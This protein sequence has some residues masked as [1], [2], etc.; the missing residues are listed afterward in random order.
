MNFNIYN[1]IIIT[2]IIQGFIFTGI[3]CLV[4]K[5]H[6]KSTYALAAIIFSYTI[7]NSIFILPDLGIMSHS[8]MYL[9]YFLPLAS[10]FAPLIYLYVIFFLNPYKQISVK[11]YLLFLPFSLFFLGIMFF[12]FSLLLGYFSN[13]VVNNYFESIIIYHDLFSIIYSVIILIITFYHVIKYELKYTSFNLK[14]IR[15]EIKWLKITLSLFMFF[16]LLY[17]YLVVKDIF[18]SEVEINYYSLWIAMSILIY[19]LGHYGIYN[20]AIIIDRKDIRNFNTNHPYT[21]RIKT[22][23]NLHINDLKNLLLHQK[24]YLDSSLSLE[25]VAEKLKISSSYLSRI[26]H[27]ELN[28]SFTDYIHSLRIEE[29]KTYLLNPEFSDYTITSIGLEA[30]FNSR[31]SFFDI[32]KKETGQTPLEYK[33]THQKQ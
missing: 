17:G 3:V 31:S 9:Y 5:Y 2:G 6:S 25:S 30:G 4:K 8:N 7:M 23:K 11:T 12:R 24:A 26:I 14:I 21:R 29:A 33:K 16:T 20:Y 22:S 10:T 19:W 1:I 13:E 27:A 15:P 18:I 32:F 28:T